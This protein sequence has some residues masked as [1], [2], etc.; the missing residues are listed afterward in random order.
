MA[1]KKKSEEAA[2]APMKP[3]WKTT[4]FI[5]STLTA[6]LGVAI[7]GGF[8]DLEGVSALDKIA[9]LAA[10]ALAAMGYSVSRGKVKAADAW[11]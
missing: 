11:K 5:L 4:E 1:T 2:V 9:G 10:A 8:L 3:G 6:L 7:A